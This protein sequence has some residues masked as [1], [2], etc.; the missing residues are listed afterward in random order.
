M[1]PTPLCAT[2]QLIPDVGGLQVLLDM[3]FAHVTLLLSYFV[4]Y[5]PTDRFRTKSRDIHVR[6]A[7]R[8]RILWY[9]AH[10]RHL[11][12]AP[13]VYHTLHW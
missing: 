6:H 10:R 12:R 5:P 1:V 8:A 7:V 9:L 2:T 11:P 4:S 3:V 13:R